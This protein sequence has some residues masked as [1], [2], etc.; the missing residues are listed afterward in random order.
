MLGCQAAVVVLLIDLTTFAVSLESSIE[1]AEAIGA[2]PAIDRDDSNRPFG[3]LL[4]IEVAEN[5]KVTYHIVMRIEP[6]VSTGLLAVAPSGIFV[7]P[8]SG[9]T[10]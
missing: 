8:Y 2:D 1:R 3:N 9:G 5:L 6:I 10:V 4:A 7:G